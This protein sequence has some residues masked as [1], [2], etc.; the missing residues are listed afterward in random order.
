VIFRPGHTLNED[1]VKER[2]FPV[3]LLKRNRAAFA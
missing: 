3:A 1:P 2:E